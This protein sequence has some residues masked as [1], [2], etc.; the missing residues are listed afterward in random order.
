MRILIF[1]RR[2]LGGK[3]KLDEIISECEKRGVVVAIAAN[4]VENDV[5]YYLK[6][7]QKM[8]DKPLNTR[9]VEVLREVRGEHENHTIKDLQDC[10]KCHF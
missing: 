5:L 7:Y 1:L 10:C 6:E 3:M 8:L 9:L 4:D 2:R